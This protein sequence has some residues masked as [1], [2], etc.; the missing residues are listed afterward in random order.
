VFPEDGVLEHV[1]MWE[2]PEDVI[3]VDTPD[4]EEQQASASEAALAVEMGLAAASEEANVQ[5]V[6]SLYLYHSEHRKRPDPSSN[7]HNKDSA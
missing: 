7:R 5:R 1:V 3:V 2:G 4:A 6:V